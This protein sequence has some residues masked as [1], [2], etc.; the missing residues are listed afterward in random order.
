MTTS[1]EI[2]GTTRLKGGGRNEELGGL[3]VELLDASGH[4][5][6]VLRSAYDGFFEF[7]DLAFG[8]YLLRVTDAEAARMKIKPA[9]RRLSI[10]ANHNFL[11]GMDLIVEPRN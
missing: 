10:K 8:D 4:Q 7:G 11:D 1:G 6:K 3:E 5:V 2:T 9:Q